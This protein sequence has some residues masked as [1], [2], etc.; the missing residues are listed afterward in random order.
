LLLFCLD[1]DVI[2]AEILHGVHAAFPK[3]TIFVRAYDRRSVM[4]MAGAP[5]AGV[6]RELF[7]SAVV[8]ARR[9]MDAVGVDEAEIDK[10]EAEYRKRDGERLQLQK[11]T[12]DIRARNSPFTRDSYAAQAAKAAAAEA[13]VKAE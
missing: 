3:A 1:G 13:D 9:A 2:D 10:T 4:K 11:D 8:M 5:V 12:G 7:E 6:V